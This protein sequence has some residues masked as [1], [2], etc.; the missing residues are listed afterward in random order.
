MTIRLEAANQPD[1]IE[2]ITALDE[3]QKPLYPAESHHGIDLAALS[4]ANVLF[5][6]A[7]HASGVALACGA[8][9]LQA[10]Y[11]EVKRMYTAPDARGQGLALAL[12]RRLESE[13]ARR[14]V[15]DFRLETGY[16]QPQAIRLY[17]Q[18]GYRRCGPFGA[19]TDDPNSVFMAKPALPAGYR[20]RLARLEETD[21]L[22]RLIARSAREVARGDYADAAI[23]G[24]LQGAFGVDT[25]L[26]RDGTYFV[27]EHREQPVAVGGWSRR[28]TLFGSDARADRD[29]ALLD[30]A[31]DGARIRAFFVH[32]DHLRRG[33]GTALLTAGEIAARAEGFRSFELMATRT[34]RPLYL[35]HGYRGDVGV[36]HPLDNGVSIEFFPMSKADPGLP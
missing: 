36:Q 24:A 30:P 27:V 31:T 34:G 35:R 11:G 15:T 13:A 12:L 25:Q 28:R 20:L 26:L 17:E 16:R 8:V 21:A 9:V 22:D 5:A 10:G 19:Y 29:P 32:P 4:S 18:A 7:R 3:Y 6:V 14:G 23:E 1:V 33:L 2:L